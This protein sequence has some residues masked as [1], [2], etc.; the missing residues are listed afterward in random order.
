MKRIAY[1]VP[2][3]GKFPEN[4]PLWLI[5][6]EKNPTV[7][8]LIFTD[9]RTKYSYPPNVKV[10]YMSFEEMKE[11]IQRLFDFPIVLDKPWKICDYRV[12]FGEIFEKE[13]MGY[14]FW[15]HCDLDM[16][17][18]NIRNFL[19]NDILEK[20][21][22]IG[23][24][25]HSTLYKNNPEVNV[26][27]KA[28]IEEAVDYKTVFTSANAYGF[29]ETRICGIYDAL[30]IDYYKKTIYAHLNKYESS[31]YLGHLTKDDVYKNKHQVFCWSDGILTRY[32]LNN[33][34]V[35]TEEFMYIHF[36]CRPITYRIQGC[37]SDDSFIMYPD[38][39]KKCDR[40]VDVKFLKKYGHKGKIPFLLKSLYRSRKKITLKRII[41]NFK[42]FSRYRKRDVR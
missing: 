1:I 19:T 31:F 7:D 15:G 10:V 38:V 17:W 36:W 25:G 23:N 18:G 30:G 21:E 4:F 9:D 6:C 16:V 39:V 20:Y 41:F 32:Y 5:S 13:L 33:K 29:D 28:C 22:K 27:Y 2:Y 3:F 11:K 35:E 26:R 37:T 34:K 24:Q 40:P 12:A 42:S 8:W 14:D